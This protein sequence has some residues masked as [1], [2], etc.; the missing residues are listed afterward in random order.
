[1]AWGLG[2]AV[3]LLASCHNSCQNICHRMAAYGEECGLSIPD[4]EIAACI[5][6]QSS[7]E[8][9]DLKACRL[10]GDPES[11]RQQWSCEDLADYW[12]GGDD[13]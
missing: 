2:L 7:S 1:M 8:R 10:Y 9:E 5:E 13:Q 11:I 12:S 4:G 6:R 3:V